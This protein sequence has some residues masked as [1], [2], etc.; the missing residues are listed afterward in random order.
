[1]GGGGG[2]GGG[3]EGAGGV[4]LSAVRGGTEEDERGGQNW[5]RRRVTSKL[6]NVPGAQRPPKKGA[7]GLDKKG[8]RNLPERQKRDER[9]ERLKR[10]IAVWKKKHQLLAVS[11][12]HL[13][14]TAKQGN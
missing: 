12:H 10:T 3:T 4:G 7:E 13:P 14:S 11:E 5:S 8:N 1:V 6:Q 9:G 2:G